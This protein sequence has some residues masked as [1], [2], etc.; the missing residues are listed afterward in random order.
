MTTLERREAVHPEV[1]PHESGGLLDWITT[2]DH[3]KIGI[4]YT[5]TALFF[6]LVA[7][8]QLFSNHTYNEIM[9]MHGTAMIFFFATPAVIG[10]GNYISPLQIG[11]PDVAFPR[12]NAMTYWMSLSGA[13]MAFS[14][15]ITSSGAAQF[16]WTA[17]APLT[18]LQYSPGY[19]PDLWL[20]GIVLSGT[21]TILGAINLLATILGM[22]APG[23]TMFRLSMFNW[24]ILATMI[25]IMFA[26]PA[27]SAGF[28]MTFID[29]R[30]GG[31]FFDPTHG[32]DAI[33]YQH[34]FWFFGH[35]EVYIV[36]LPFFGILSE[37]IPVFSRKPLFGYRGFVL[38][39][40]LIT[41][42]SFSVWA[43]HMFAT[44]AVNGPFFMATTMLIAVPT[45]I[46]FYNW[47]AT[48]WRG[49]L[50]FETPMLFCMG[51]LFT[52]LIGG[53]TGM[54]LASPAIDY[55]LHDT[56][57]VVAH[58]HFVMAFGT[59]FGAFAGIYFWFPKVTGRLMNETLGKIHF[60]LLLAG[61]FITFLPQFQLG[62][63]G[64]Q[65][66]IAD[67][68]GYP[69]YDTLN[70]ISSIGAFIIGTSIL[71]FVIDVFYSL[72]RGEVA[73]PDPWNGYSLEWATSSPPPH[74]NF[75]RIPPIR[76]ERPVFD[77]RERLRRQT[78]PSPETA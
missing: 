6:M 48:M 62:I 69:Q 59:V 33:L 18:H 26:F 64:M 13:L 66:R 37:V 45:G 38:A 7:G 61:S 2:I 43:H 21:A 1:V 74:H 9:T 10:L 11:A 14:G 72:K 47:T 8:L 75:R 3:K 77:E 5:G 24:N 27:L 20:G 50:S 16:G 41:L 15:F 31:H 46:K 54:Y 39:T 30:L 68:A 78:A 52:F 49:K 44:G 35:P 4:L 12:L 51:F 53:I 19:G 22:R 73:G 65:R 23:M 42:Y 67:Y 17:Y 70:F 71:V 60:W 56:Y 34:L 76:S 63:D 57:Y 29:R 40:L 25:L 55:P 58:F 32:G 36:I 28:I